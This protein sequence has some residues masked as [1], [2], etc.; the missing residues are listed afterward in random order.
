MAVQPTYNHKVRSIKVNKTDND[1]QELRRELRSA[2]SL[3][4]QHTDATVEYEILSRKEFDT[5]WYFDVEVPW[6]ISGSDTTGADT[7]IEPAFTEDFRN[8]EYN[9][10]LNNAND[11]SK[12]RIRQ[13]VDYSTGIEDPV[14]LPAILANAAGRAELQE[15]NYTAKG[16]KSGKYEGKQLSGAVINQYTT[17]DISIGKDPVVESLGANLIEFAWGGG[18]SP[19]I[20]GA[21]LVNTSKILTVGNTKDNVEVVNKNRGNFDQILSQA[22][23]PGDQVQ[24]TQYGSSTINTGKLKVLANNISV[25]AVSYMMPSGVPDD[26]AKFANLI[27]TSGSTHYDITFTNNIPLVRVDDS[28]NKYTTGSKVSRLEVFTD[29]SSSLSQGE[30]VF[31]TFYSTL[32]DIA[33][34]NQTGQVLPYR[35]ISSSNSSTPLEYYGVREIESIEQTGISANTPGII[36]KTPL[37]TE[38]SSEGLGSGSLGAFIWKSGDENIILEGSTLSGLGPGALYQEFS[39]DLIVDEL[40]YITTTYGSNPG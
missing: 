15:F 38:L 13:V 37:P 22:V 10:L 7:V 35:F 32:G 27:E 3:V 16:S 25:S 11:N 23:L 12:S 31:I 21:G 34:E 17:G 1:S 6:N 40:D 39:S 29:I 5:Y 24:L 4:I 36:L 28:T 14:N 8:S 18:T 30:R 19:V 26:S 20:L 2:Q 9:A 33:N